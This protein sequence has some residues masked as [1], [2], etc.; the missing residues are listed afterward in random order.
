MPD[1][2]SPV[3]KSRLRRW[4][5]VVVAVF[6]VATGA[7]G[8]LWFIERDNHKATDAQITPAHMARQ[9][10]ETR[11]QSAQRR[12]EENTRLIP[13]LRDEA[14]RARAEA[15][16]NND[17][18]NAGRAILK[19]TDRASAQAARALLTQFCE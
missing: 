9:Q 11:L 2:N 4:L 5:L 19:A 16:A 6:V 18:A 13:L 3:Q 15:D 10:A 12:V 14:A 17:C 7:F 1:E 8:T